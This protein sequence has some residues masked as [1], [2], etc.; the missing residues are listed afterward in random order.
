MY[1][2]SLPLCVIDRFLRSGIY[3]E[4]TFGQLC[5]SRREKYGV[6]IAEVQSVGLPTRPFAPQLRFTLC[7]D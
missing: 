6:D 1:W 2:S 4:T 5:I 7:R 3:T